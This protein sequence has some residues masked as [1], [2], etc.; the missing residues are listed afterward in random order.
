MGQQV[1][2]KVNFFLSPTR[3]EWG[4]RCRCSGCLRETLTL[5]PPLGRCQAAGP[6][7]S[8]L[9]PVPSCPLPSDHSQ[10]APGLLALDTQGSQD[11]GLS[12]SYVTYLP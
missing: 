12:S 1:R 7:D 2:S 9:P 6:W 8:T 5:A 3:G 4:P 11:F 10:Q